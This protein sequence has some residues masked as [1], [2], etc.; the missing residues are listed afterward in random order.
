VKEERQLDVLQVTPKEAAV[1]LNYSLATIYALMSRQ[2]LR[3]V[4]T[5]KMRRIPVSELKDWQQRNMI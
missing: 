3:Y 1:M 4:G 2:E 5:R